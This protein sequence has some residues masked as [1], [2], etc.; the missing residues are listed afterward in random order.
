MAHLQSGETMLQLT[1][2]GLVFQGGLDALR[3][4]FA[5]HHYVVLKNLLEPA[6]LETVQRQMERVPWRS[7]TFDEVGTEFTLDDPVSVRL[8]LFVLNSPKFLN[9]IRF[10]TGCAQISDFSGRVYRLSAGSQHQLSWHSDTNDV[11]RQVGFSLNV[12]AD[13]FRGGTFELRDRRTLAPLAQ[14]DNTGFGD[15]LLFRISHDLQHRVTPVVDTVAKT[16][17]AGWF[18]ATGKSLFAE[19]VAAQ[20]APV[21]MG[22]IRGH[23]FAKLDHNREHSMEE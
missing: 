2:N 8:L 18:R 9:V 16:A 22:P 21:Q 4:C 1:R 7:S 23:G 11:Q 3:D 13:V 19:L 6:L 17:C 15:A 12:S 10:I 20:N 5:T 14:V